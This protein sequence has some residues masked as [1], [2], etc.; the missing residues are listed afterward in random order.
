MQKRTLKFDCL[1][2]MAIFSKQVTSGFLMNT[3]NFTLT[4]KFSEKDID[5]A[6]NKYNAAVIETTDKVFSYESLVWYYLWAD[7]NFL[8]SV[9]SIRHSTIILVFAEA[10][11]LGYFFSIQVWICC[12]AIFA[13]NSS[14]RGTWFRFFIAV[15]YL[16][17]RKYS[18]KVY[19]IFFSSKLFCR[20]NWVLLWYL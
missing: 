16:V 2:N 10:A 13:W 15:G 11:S 3:N 12:A 8:S 20:Y 18:F 1:I 14:F 6:I 9:S 19:Q 7:K 5:F 17:F 4:G